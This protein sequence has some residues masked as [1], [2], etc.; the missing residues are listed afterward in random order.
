MLDAK[1]SEISEDE[2][3]NFQQQN[4]ID[5]MHAANTSA[6]N[7]TIQ[8]LFQDG[9]DV[10]LLIVMLEIPMAVSHRLG[11]VQLLRNALLS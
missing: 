3:D 4:D 6:L 10:K 2:W 5:A 8:E 1:C 9:K 7:A 11:R